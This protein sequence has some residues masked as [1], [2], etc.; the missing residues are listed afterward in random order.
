MSEDL[1]DI[2]PPD[3][4]GSDVLRRYKYQAHVAFP[5][6]LRCCTGQQVVSV[7][8]EHFEDVLVQFVDTWHMMQ[9]KTKNPDI[10]PWK[11]SDALGKSGGIRGLARTYKEVK[12]QK[13]TFGLYLEGAISKNDDLNK[14]V[15]SEKEITEELILNVSTALE[16][17]VEDT[18]DLLDRLTVHPNMPHRDNISATNIRILGRA[19]PT[20][21]HGEL[22]AVYS[23]C[24]DKIFRAMEGDPLGPR[25]T[26]LFLPSDDNPEYIS[27]DIQA[28]RL[29]K[30]SLLEF[31]GG[32]VEGTYPLLRRITD[33]QKDKP[34]NL[35]AKLI[36]GGADVNVITDAKNLRANASIRIA[37]I[38]ALSLFGNDDVLE[39]VGLRLVTLS[40]S[41]IQKYN[42]EEHPAKISWN[43]IL[44]R[45][46]RNPGYAD[47]N[48]VFRQDPFLLLGYVCELTDMCRITWG[49]PIA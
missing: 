2:S 42:D 29:T 24:I 46:E 9:I 37:Q 34:T 41:V 18:R 11:L 13:V 10:G 35:E 17:S 5:F 6:C 14:L 32:V 22:E 40:N 49:V 48:Q 16:L 43:E 20:T 25:I 33:I 28:K 39:D 45:L 44:E 15:I 31:L 38:S 4:T 12:D 47:P 7:F 8:V 36:A 1:L 27:T 26:E 21:P 23:K 3:N 30:E 19:A